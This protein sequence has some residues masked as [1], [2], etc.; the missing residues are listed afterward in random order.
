M[1][2]I[3]IYAWWALLCSMYILLNLQHIVFI[4]KRLFGYFGASTSPC[5]FQN[6]LVKFH[7]KL[8]WNLDCDCARFMH[9]IEWWRMWMSSLPIY[10]VYGIA[11]SLNS[12]WCLSIKFY[13][14]LHT[15]FTHIWLYSFHSL[16]FSLSHTLIYIDIP[17]VFY[18]YHYIFIP[19]IV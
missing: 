3:S 5:K 12:L 11:V 13:N 16:S 6:Q 1:P 7:E 14:Y 17:Y 4:T 15:G 19:Y 8:Y 18:F 10:G 2:E 9:K